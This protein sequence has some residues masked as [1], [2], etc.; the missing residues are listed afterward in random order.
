MAI[1]SAL[2]VSSVTPDGSQIRI[3]AFHK[4]LN[5]Q[6]QLDFPG[7]KGSGVY[8]KNIERAC[9]GDCTTSDRGLQEVSANFL[10]F[11]VVVRKAA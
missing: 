6:K 8:L 5:Q 9:R 4:E 11:F 3:P 10:K 7:N 2:T 1:F